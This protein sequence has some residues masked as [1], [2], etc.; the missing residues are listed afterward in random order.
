MNASLS[1]SDTSFVESTAECNVH[2]AKI[3]FYE[4]PPWSPTLN[5]A[6]SVLLVSN[7]DED[8]Y[9]F[10]KEFGT[11][12]TVGIKLGSSFRYLFEMEK[13]SLVKMESMGLSV[14]VAAS[15]W[16]MSASASTTF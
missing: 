6:L 1:K 11:H 16:G 5:S 8:Y 9:N 2:E 3:K 7:N 13:S 15:G 14:S 10:Y 12:V 4:Q